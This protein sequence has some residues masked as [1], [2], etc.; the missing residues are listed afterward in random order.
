M[1]F[2]RPAGT[3]MC[4]GAV[5]GIAA[6]IPTPWLL[7]GFALGILAAAAFVLVLLFGLIVYWGRP[8]S[9]SLAGAGILFAFLGGI[10]SVTIIWLGGFPSPVSELAV[11]LGSLGVLGMCVSLIGCGIGRVPETELSDGRLFNRTR[12]GAV[13]ICAGAA[14]GLIGS[15]LSVFGPFAF[16]KLGGFVSVLFFGVLLFQDRPEGRLLA[17]ATL[18]FAIV[19]EAADLVFLLGSV[20]F[21]GAS[22][23]ILPGTFGMVLAVAGAISRL[24]RVPGE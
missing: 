14:L 18:Y 13:L 8:P 10:A 20:F 21:G 23:W 16:L 24:V 1:G 15:R 19:A 17:A 4:T 2:D 12:L 22:F 7:Y 5:V 11:A 6:M 3:L 9:R